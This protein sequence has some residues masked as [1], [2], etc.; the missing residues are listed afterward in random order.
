MIFAVCDNIMIFAVCDN[1]MI[2]NSTTF[3]R[4]L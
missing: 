4:L 3:R 1:I 2:L